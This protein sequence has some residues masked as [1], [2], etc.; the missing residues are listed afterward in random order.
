LGEAASPSIEDQS[1]IDP[2]GND[3]PEVGAWT[4]NLGEGTPR[5]IIPDKERI[6]FE[7]EKLLS[8]I[9]LTGNPGSSTKSLAFLRPPENVH[10]WLA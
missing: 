9:S 5:C 2:L 6:A 3:A 1:E 8:C 10:S 4:F 7:A